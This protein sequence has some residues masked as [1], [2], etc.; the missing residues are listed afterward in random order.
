MPNAIQMRCM[1]TYSLTAVVAEVWV[2]K[3]QLFVELGAHVHAQ[4]GGEAHEKEYPTDK[5]L[6]EKSFEGRKRHPLPIRSFSI[7]LE[8]LLALS[9]DFC[10]HHQFGLDWPWRNLYH[11]RFWLPQPETALAKPNDLNHN[12][13]LLLPREKKLKVL[14]FV[15][16]RLRNKFIL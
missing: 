5:N 4:L 6:A 8:V 9:K 12:S 10:Q 14:S 3:A 11:L 13:L 2:Q 7:C 15:S 1:D 16:K